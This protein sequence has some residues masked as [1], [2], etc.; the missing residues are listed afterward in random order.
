MTRLI[1]APKSAIILL[2]EKD[3]KD[4]HTSVDGELTSSKSTNH[5]ETSA[6]ARVRATET[7]L[8]AD[9]DK[10]RDSAL[11][12]ETLG[13]VDLGEHSVGRLGDNGGSETSNQTRA[14]ADDGLGAIGQRVLVNKSVDSLSDLLVDDEL[15]NGVRNPMVVNCVHARVRKEHEPTV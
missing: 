3:R 9:L 12:G 15:G 5:E 14:Q 7:E 8:L 11:T 1:S 6:N 13:L 4:R 10:A 2:Q